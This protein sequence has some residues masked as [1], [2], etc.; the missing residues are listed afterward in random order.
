MHIGIVCKVIDNFGDAG[1]SLRLAKA[2][3]AK[4]HCVICFH[5][6]PA[7]FS[8]A[9]SAPVNDNLR[10]I[11]AVKTNIETE[12]RQTPDLILEPFGT[13]GQTAF[14][15]DLALKSRFPLHPLVAD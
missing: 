14:R 11:D 15:F 4:G 8:G 10:L 1:F 2:L 7:T 3:A 13:S 6:E 9:I 12:Y 5:D